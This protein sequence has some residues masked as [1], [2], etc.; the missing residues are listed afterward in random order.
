MVERATRTITLELR[1]GATVDWDLELG[2]VDSRTAIQ[3]RYGGSNS[4]GI[5]AP[6][7]G[8]DQKDVML[9]W[10]PQRGR[11][12]G[13]DDGWTSDG[14]TFFFSGTGVEGDQQFGAPLQENG[15]VRDH[16][17]NGDRI[18]LLKYL[19]KNRVRYVAELRLVQWHVRDGEDRKGNL[20]KLIQFQ[21]V[22]VGPAV[23][24]PGD[25]ERPPL[26]E[27][28]APA[29]LEPP[30]AEPGEA[31]LERLHSKEFRRHL[32]TQQLVCRRREAELVHAFAQ[33]LSVTFGRN[34][35]GYEIPYGV[36]GRNLRADAYLP[37]RED[38]G[39]ILFEAKSS[40]AREH[41]RLA[42]GQ[43]LDYRRYIET[44]PKL[45]VLTPTP[46]PS[47]MLELLDELGIGIVWQ[48]GDG[49]E[50]RHLDLG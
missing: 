12:F 1:L 19:G 26:R 16:V 17:A 39:G 35:T 7:A 5:S 43:L 22:P 21:F 46:V 38:A 37:P 28:P 20:R 4:R 2:E 48:S 13:Y 31:A 42:I 23:Q 40:A 8:G 11:E 47:D 34:V 29:P 9:W 15:R 44:E 33:W 25:L 36:E 32:M 30:P 50:A 3:A 10:D 6:A 27:A 41:V 24:E 45:A 49:F 14:S 18:R